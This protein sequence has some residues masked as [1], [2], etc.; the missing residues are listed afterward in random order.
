MSKHVV[1]FVMSPYLKESE[2]KQY[3]DSRREFLAECVHTNETAV[4]Y[5]KW[6]LAQNNEKIS[7]VYAL[8]SRFVQKNAL[9]KFKEIFADED[10]IIQDVPLQQDGDLQGSFK[11]I[12]TMFD[13]LN[14]DSQNEELIVHAD[15][16][17][18]FRHSSVLMLDLLQMLQYIGAKVGMVLYTNFNKQI[19]EEA[20][21]LIS[22]F[23]LIAGA[24][25]FAN[26]GN[27]EQIKQY[28]SLVSNKSEILVDLLDKMEDFSERIKISS[29]LADLQFT[30]RELDESIQKYKLFLI[31]A[32]KDTISEQEEFFG[33]LLPTIEKEYADVISQKD[34]ISSIPEIIKWC[35]NKGLL[36]Q[37]LTFYTE[38][39]PV[40][41]IHSGI[42]IILDEDIIKFCKKH[43]VSWSNWEVYFFK[44]YEN[45]IEQ[46]S[47]DINNDVNADDGMSYETFRNILELGYTA[48][49]IEYYLNG[50]KN[51]FN[52][53]INEIVMFKFRYRN[54]SYFD[55]VINL[56]DDDF[57]KMVLLESTPSNNTFENYI[58]KRLQNTCGKIEEIF[59]SAVKALP[60][61]RA[62]ELFSL[63]K[64]P[65]KCKAKTRGELFRFLLKKGKIKSLLPESV[66]E[67]F[68]DDY[69]K[70]I[71]D[72]RNTINHASGVTKGRKENYS[73]SRSI[74][75]NIQIIEKYYKD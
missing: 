45:R 40:F 58:I 5:I 73:L 63:S 24:A 25:E 8:V 55:A 30:I 50:P 61:E 20:G 34:D 51:K 11:S 16:T 54:G 7:V 48:A 75:E 67:S 69:K 59:F 27:V 44:N 62:I 6:K 66:L 68:V 21:D 9:T 17:G 14:A 32:E 26:H 4:K 38:W 42:V 3:T 43:N 37:A 12:S 57:L 71:I 49:E 10:F 36:Q 23:T 15:M 22:L 35:A 2:S 39:L 41:L 28:F 19:V 33:K 72:R 53:F 31:N 65:V 18:G 1:I 64:E 52:N 13:I 70:N 56:P 29:N 74:I 46:I 60:K 47:E